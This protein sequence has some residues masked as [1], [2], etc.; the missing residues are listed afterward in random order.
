MQT[1][2]SNTTPET[3]S[4]DAWRY[5]GASMRGSSHEITGQPCQDAHC[6][7][8]VSEDFFVTAIADGAGSATA[9]KAGADLAVQT[10]VQEITK[11]LNLPE[12]QLTDDEWQMLMAQV[13]KATQAALN[14]EAALR[15]LPVRELATTLILVVATP[16]LVVAAQV[17]DGAAV[18]RD[19]KGHVLA[20][21][22]PQ[23]GEYINE[24]T[25]MTSPNALETAQITVWRGNISHLAVFSDGLQMLCLKMPDCTPH[26]GFFSPLFK[27]ITETNDKVEAEAELM[28]FLGSSR[29]R[30][31]TN[32]DM[33]IVLAAVN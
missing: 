9:A 26:E 22:I 3:P 30:N 28:R 1:D 4:P 19:K 2:E 11:R 5:A 29:I 14:N 32:D 6:I 24:T 10:G 31:L 18:I 33:T 15:N 16:N 7:A 27:F 8:N 25:F 12:K 13:I 17:G 20:L 23:A 21:T